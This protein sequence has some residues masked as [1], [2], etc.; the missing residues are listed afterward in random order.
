M[1]MEGKTLRREKFQDKSCNVDINSVARVNLVVKLLSR[2]H[3]ECGVGYTAVLFQ[4][5]LLIFICTLIL[6]RIINF[7]L[8]RLD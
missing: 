4:F 3:A 5:R 6:F 7:S 8:L 2:D 1:A